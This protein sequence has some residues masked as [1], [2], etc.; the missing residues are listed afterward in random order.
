[1]LRPYLKIWD[2]AWIFGRAV[3]AI[4][5]LGV[6]SPCLER[7]DEFLVFL[8]LFS[9]TGFVSL[10]FSF[11]KQQHFPNVKLEIWKSKQKKYWNFWKKEKV[12][13]LYKMS[14]HKNWEILKIES[15]DYCLEET[16]RQCSE[17]K[18]CPVFWNSN[19]ILIFI[20]TFVLSVKSRF[21]FQWKYQLILERKI[22]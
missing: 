2:W 10:F 14:V 1:M 16:L 7:F 11:S 5:S 6:R 12:Y 13:N 15:E 19:P 8:S 21:F 22:L 9:V 17:G 20:R 18:Y 3:K 4:S